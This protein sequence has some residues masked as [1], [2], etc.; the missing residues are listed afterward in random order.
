MTDVLASIE[1]SP[2]DVG[3]LEM[4]VR[5]PAPA[6]REILDV[7]ELTTDEGLVGDGWRARGSRHTPDGS[8]EV[9]RQLTLMNSRAV[10]IVAG[11]RERWPLAGDQLY[12]DFDLSHENLPTGTRLRIGTAVVEVTPEPHNG[13]AKFRARYGP[14]AVRLF[15]SPDGKRLRARGINA[16]VVEPGTIR[17]GDEVAKLS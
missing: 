12:I 9:N 7:G 17:V 16:R 1:A 3:S 10:A 14:E 8:P 6:E 13:C 11:E 2:R 4:I 15:N 5:R